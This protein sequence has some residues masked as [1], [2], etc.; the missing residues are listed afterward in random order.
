MRA[1]A[2]PPVRYPVGRTPRLA[3][4]LAALWLL[5]VGAAVLVLFDHPAL[6]YKAPAAIVLVVFLVLAG[7]GLWQF[8][9]HQRPRTLIWDGA[10]WMLEPSD[11]SDRG[12]AAHP[13]VRLD[14][15]FIMLLRLYVPGHRP[16]WLWCEAAHDP[17]RWHLLRCAIYSSAPS[18][19]AE[20]ALDERA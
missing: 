1:D 9:R 3:T 14:L 16:V 17:A 7:G 11:G 13:Q 19:G 12:D 2:A 18:A 8:W 10:I 6:V 15:Q 4:L 20:P 5:G